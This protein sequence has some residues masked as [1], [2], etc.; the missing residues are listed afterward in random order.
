MSWGKVAEAMM[1]GD[2]VFTYFQHSAANCA[3]NCKFSSEQNFGYFSLNLAMNNS[4]SSCSLRPRI[5]S[6]LIFP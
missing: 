1:M 2:A 5:P 6:F 3:A 4:V